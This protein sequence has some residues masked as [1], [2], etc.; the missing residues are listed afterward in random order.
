[1]N[2]HWAAKK[3]QQQ[4]GFLLVAALGFIV[5]FSFLIF[6][7]TQKMM[8]ASNTQILSMLSIQSTNAANSGVEEGVYLLTHQQQSLRNCKRMNLTQQF[9]E[10]GLNNCTVHTSCNVNTDNESDKTL[11]A[12]I[13]II[14]TQAQCGSNSIYATSAI[15][16]ALHGVKQASGDQQFK[17]MYRKLK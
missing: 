2:R 3:Y 14:S 5:V 15:D 8:S 11:G 4:G 1:M 10:I 12:S 9:S 17:I 6:V 16:V 13:Y 7:L